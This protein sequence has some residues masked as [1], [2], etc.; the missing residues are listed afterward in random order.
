VSCLTLRV[1]ADEFTVRASSDQTGGALFAGEI[2]MPPG[3]G[4]PR[5]HRH[6]PSEIYHVLEGEFVFYVGDA[7]TVAGPGEIV[8]IAGGVAHT[9]RNQSESRAR[10][11]V[12]YA[13]GEVMERFAHAAAA[14]STPSID[15]VLSL[16]ERHG[17]EMLP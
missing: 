9:I 6:A 12:V 17:I 8:P 16:A 10:A 7:V 4:P 1:G 15:D 14:L 13:P 11:L 3:G 5:M 2:A